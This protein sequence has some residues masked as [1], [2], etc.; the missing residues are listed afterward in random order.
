MILLRDLPLHTEVIDSSLC[1]DV[2]SRPSLIRVRVVLV[3]CACGLITHEDRF[4]YQ[5]CIDNSDWA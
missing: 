3:H 5:R 4:M 1:P 2:G